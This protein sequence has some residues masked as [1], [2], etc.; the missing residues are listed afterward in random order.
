M[1][2]RH[3]FFVAI[4]VALSP[5]SVSMVEAQ[6]PENWDCANRDGQWSCAP[7]QTSS[8]QGE[9]TASQPGISAEEIVP[10][11]L[12]WVPLESIPEG[13][14]TDLDCPR[15]CQGVYLAPSRGGSDQLIDPTTA[16]MNA[17]MDI[18]ELD[19]ETGVVNLS[20]DV[21]F[22][23]GWRQVAADEVVVDRNRYEMS[24]N[25]TIREP[26]LLLTGESAS[27]D[28]STNELQLE[29]AQYVLHDIRVQGSADQIHRAENGRIYI[30]NATYSTCEPIN[31][32][33]R[34]V[35]EEV[36]IDPEN[37]RIVASDMY[38][39]AGSVPIFYAPK[40]SFPLGDNRKSGLLYPVFENSGINGLDIA[41]PIYLNLAPNYDLTLT[42]R[43]I[44]ERGAMLESQLRWLAP[45]IS[46]SLDTALLIDDRGGT[47]DSRRGDD[48]WFTRILSDWQALDGTIS[49]DYNAASDRDYFNDLGTASL[50]SS[51]QT[52]LNQQLG[53]Q[54]QGKLFDVSLSAVSYQDL[55]QNELRG[56]N[57]L[58]RIQVTSNWQSPS[59]FY[60]NTKQ[61]VV[62]F[63]PLNKRTLPGSVLQTDELGNWIEGERFRLDY[64]GGWQLSSNSAKLD[65]GALFGYRQYRLNQALLSGTDSSPDTVAGGVYLDTQLN[66]E[67]SSASGTQTLTP[68]LQYLFVDA[69]EQSHLP[70][71]DSFEPQLNYATM[72]RLNRFGGGDRIAD[73]NQ[74]TLGLE[75]SGFSATGRE[76]LRLGIAQQF[77]LD[78]R[79]VHANSQLAAGLVDPGVFAADDPR[80]LEA[81][82]GQAEYN[83]L[84]S[85]H[86]SLATYA[87]L[88]LTQNWYSRTML[89]WSDS[90]GDIDYGT[91]ELGYRSPSSRSLANIAYHY[92][93]RSP[94]FRDS[95]D[96]NLVQVG[97]TI[98]GSIEQLDFSAVLEFSDNWTL[99]GKWQQDVT[100]SRPLEVLAG[101]RYDACCWSTSLVWRHWLK[102]DD[103]Q[104]LPEQALRHDNGI[105]VSFELK[106]LAGV[107]ERLE[108]MLSGSIPGY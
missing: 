2:T 27:I 62:A 89:N 66:F 97:E 45:T 65:A 48:R 78:E 49:L 41:Q 57:E 58:P 69:D 103:N 63:S 14:A 26:N 70:I 16:E 29:D 77:Y 72:F 13:M 43:Y 46:G 93:K 79:E 71:F 50:Q 85:S 95:N 35:A 36:E 47:N 8:P 1:P 5:A 101:A 75:S 87:E 7:I 59:H 106:G 9:M 105:F 92:E 11:N 34:F 64:Q 44:E 80:R 83:R 61:E 51:N 6:S 104:L 98:D 30:D 67:R 82:A 73:A 102:R 33:W 28:A 108:N 53:Y 74:L 25:I 94:V 81:Q 20:G 39:K 40:I 68:R 24:G 22:T 17:E 96:D 21:L 32:S 52:W 19:A 38:I 76:T 10:N 56:F 42:P 88:F 31:E 55:T 12:D 4:A 91:V 23:Q 86:S 3:L 18:S 84:S 15:G 60:L 99:I 54:R 107:G 37:M 100:H 90:E